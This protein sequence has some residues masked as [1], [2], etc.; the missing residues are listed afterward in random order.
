MLNAQDVQGV[1]FKSDSYLNVDACIGMF[2]IGDSISPGMV[3]NMVGKGSKYP[4]AYR[5]RDGDYL[6]GDNTYKLSIPGPVPAGNF[7]R[8]PLYDAE[9]A[10]SMQN[11]QLFPPVGSLDDLQINDDQSVDLYFGPELPAGDPE[12]SWRLTV[13]GEGWFVLFR[14]FSPAKACSDGTWRPG[15]FTKVN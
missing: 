12:S 7:W 5:D 1:G 9:N 10:S 13:P 3:R 8:V 2:I 6:M 11:D 14:L 15:D 4:F